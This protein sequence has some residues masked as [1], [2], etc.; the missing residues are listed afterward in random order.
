MEEGRWPK[1]VFN[2]MLCKRKK[3][4]MK[5]NNKWF[6]K[7]GI[8]LNTCPIN[9]KEIKDFVMDKFHTCTWGKELGRKKKHYIEVFTPIN[10][11]QKVYIDVNIYYRDKIII[12]L[13]RTNSHQLC[14]ETGCWKRPKEVWDQRV[15]VFFFY[16]SGNRKYFHFRMQGLQRQQE[17]LCRYYGS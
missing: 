7:W 3:N 5:K 1:V 17:N 12:A 2:D 16:K 13:L 6:S 8:F 11:Q 4:W 15:C 9:I 14:C 10:H